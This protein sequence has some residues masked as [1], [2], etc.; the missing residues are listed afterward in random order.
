RP[1]RRSAEGA[2]G[3]PSRGARRR[4]PR[5]QRGASSM[6][7]ALCAAAPEFCCSGG[8][9]DSIQG[10]IARPQ[11]YAAGSPTGASFTAEPVPWAKGGALSEAEGLGGGAERRPS[12]ASTAELRPHTPAPNKRLPE[13]RSASLRSAPAV[14]TKVGAAS[15]PGAAALAQSA[16]VPAPKCAWWRL[17]SCYGAITADSKDRQAKDIL[18]IRP[19]LPLVAMA[20]KHWRPWPPIQDKALSRIEALNP[21]LL[22]KNDA[23]EDTSEY[24]QEFAVTLTMPY[25]A[26]D[27]DAHH[28]KQSD[29]LSRAEKRFNKSQKE[30]IKYVAQAENAKLDVDALKEDIRAQGAATAAAAMQGVTPPP[31]PPPAPPSVDAMGMYSMQQQQQQQRQQM[32]DLVR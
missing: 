20:H 15:P 7:S 14:L 19:A 6:G 17:G 22:D 26:N 25:S 29:A 1:A 27:F 9:R 11:L 13:A 31:P 16:G 30:L 10:D 8:E 24:E 12:V 4:P 2:A 23:N 18:H 21:M 3:W 28:I 5:V 32:V